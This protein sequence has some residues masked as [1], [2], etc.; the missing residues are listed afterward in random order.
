M[1]SLPEI[2]L[3]PEPPRELEDQIDDLVRVNRQL[4]EKLARYGRKDQV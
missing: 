3:P 4:K 2:P 1:N